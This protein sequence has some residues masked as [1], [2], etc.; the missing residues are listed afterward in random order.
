LDEKREKA[1]GKGAVIYEMSFFE[2]FLRSRFSI[3]LFGKRY[4][5]VPRGE[6]RKEG[7]MKKRKAARQRAREKSRRGRGRRRRKKL[8]L[9]VPTL[10]A[11]KS[12]FFFSGPSDRRDG[13]EESFFFGG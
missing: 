11:G 6:K 13:V 7:A 5:A 12:T 2:G 10:D 1:R 8:S 9:C 4:A 3:S